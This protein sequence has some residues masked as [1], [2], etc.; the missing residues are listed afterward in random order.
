[1]KD[2][3]TKL[4]NKILEALC[5]FRL[6]GEET[7]VL[8]V[9]FRKTYGFNKKKDAIALSQFVEFTKM[10]KRNIAKTIKRLEQRSMIF[11]GR[12]AINIY[13][14]NK[15]TNEWREVAK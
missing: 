7:R 9:I 10:D 15:H 8:Y 5:H 2:N 6:S 3:Y 13:E 1:M 12:G 14:F 11:V 4:S